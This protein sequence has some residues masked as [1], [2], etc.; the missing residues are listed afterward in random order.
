MELNTYL[1]ILKRHSRLILGVFIGLMIVVVVG[2]QLLPRQYSTTARLR[3]LTPV[4]GNS[5]YVDFNIWYG[6]LLM[7]TFSSMATSTTVMEELKQ[8]LGLT[9][10][11]TVSATVVANSELI[12]ITAQDKDPVRSAQITNTVADILI[13]R[14]KDPLGTGK[15]TA[16]TILTGRIAEVSKQLDAA[17]IKYQDLVTPFSKDKARVITLTDQLDQDNQLYIRYKDRYQQ[18]RFSN[19]TYTLATLQK[20]MDALKATIDQE[21]TDL[22]TLNA[23]VADVSEQIDSARKDLDLVEQEYHNLVSQLDQARVS[24]ALQENT[25][26]LVLVD[27]AVPPD[28]PTSP[29]MWLVY[30]LG[31]L[32]SFF[33]AVLVA[34]LVNNLDERIYTSDQIE[35]ITHLNQLGKIPHLKQTYGTS[36]D[37]YF[38]QE[39]IRRLR[40]NLLKVI[41]DQTI[42]ALV[43][44]S[45][46]PREGK[47]MISINIARDF[48]RGGLRTILVDADLRLPHVHL[49]F[50]VPNEV[51]LSQV[52]TGERKLED[53]IQQSEDENL[54]YLTAGPT[55]DEPGRLLGSIRMHTIINQLKGLYDLVLVDT[56]SLVAVSDVD[57]LMSFVDGVVLVVELGRVRERVLRGVVSQLNLLGGHLLGYVENF[58]DVNYKSLYYYH[59]LK[60][61]K[62]RPVKSLK[63]WDLIKDKVGRLVNYERNPRSSQE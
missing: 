30:A 57:E 27:Q 51:G 50:N 61:D 1:T 42:N 19:D 5:S 28:A 23:H 3:V 40:I 36:E 60:D 4:G 58:S 44:S 52:I 53:A 33:V 15:S 21:Q 2:A 11:P 20:D 13:S 45:A 39:S 59:H 26:T 8:K 54:H 35:A 47:S 38:L 7:N 48:A 9:E 24:F 49:N 6:T 41:Q 10:N 43:F 17:T 55:V 31:T 32:L 37:S 22:Q 16:E 12:K 56:P 18:V 14:S 29:R 34:F 63:G 62:K 25:T 46:E